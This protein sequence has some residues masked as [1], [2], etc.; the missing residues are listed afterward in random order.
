MKIIAVIVTYSSRAEYLSQ[1]VGECLSQGVDKV[2]IIDNG[3][4]ID[5][6]KKIRELQLLDPLERI[7]IHVNDKNEGSAP[8]FG[9]G[10]RLAT[11]ESDDDSWLLI[12]DD[13]N[14][15]GVG[16][17]SY[18]RTLAHDNGFYN[19]YCCLRCDR[20]HYTDFLATRD[21]KI[22][23]GA[24]NAFVYFSFIE[25]IKNRLNR[26]KCLPIPNDNNEPIHCPCGPYGGLFISTQ[27][28]KKTDSPNESLY[29][30]F[31]DTEFTLNLK[32]HGITLW[33]APQAKVF[34]IDKSWGNEKLS[35]HFSHQYL[36]ADE[37][38]MKYFF[39]NRVYLEKKYFV[40]KK[41]VYGLNIFIYLFYLGIRAVLS[42]SISKYKII[43]K[44]VIE[45]WNFGT[46][47]GTH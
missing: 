7:I 12:L 43:C 9:L 33:L 23:L 5:N 41:Y 21:Q 4:P 15:L 45:G 14:K 27:A 31:D 40:N 6:Q 8:G 42:G 11:E 10:I 38:R 35:N 39:R 18:L 3:S 20:K 32:N 17:I 1:V 25:F 26:V 16:A 22:L 36:E 30:Y 46:K 28:I 47:D 24:P 37:F 29:L 34:D 2:I 19:A 13:D 44:S